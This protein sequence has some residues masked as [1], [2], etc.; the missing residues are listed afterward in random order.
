MLSMECVARIAQ[1]VVCEH[2]E[3]PEMS[4]VAVKKAPRRA[5]SERR[6]ETS[7]AI[8][9]A[10]EKLFAEHGRDGVTVRMVGAA[11]G[12]DPALVHYYFEDL[13]GV[14]RTAFR[15]KAD[16]IN[17]IRNRCMDEYV[18][19]HGDSP[20]LEGA[21]DVF[22]RPVF[23][24]IGSDS[25]YW[26]NFA[27]M[28]AHA[29]SSRS[30]GADHMRDAFDATVHRF[31][32][33]LMKIAPEVPREEIYWFYHLLSGSL[34]ITL[35]QAGRIDSLS[36]G[37]CK[38]TDMMAVMEPMRRVFS[39]GFEATRARYAVATPVK[40]RKTAGSRSRKKTSKA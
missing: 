2:D 34:T 36:N 22:L 8:L 18:A 9:D 31:L 12:V 4:R 19:A 7:A 26:G 5:Q 14:Y 11:A 33:L 23:E 40:S 24:T 30:H 27:T 13:E 16:V 25:R 10:A 17:A 37:L 15:R 1:A 32:D 39:A 38:S 35:A 20:T 6:E 29:V 3:E 21:F 28:V